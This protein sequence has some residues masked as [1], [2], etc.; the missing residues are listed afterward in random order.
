MANRL[1]PYLTF[2][3]TAADA[4]AFYH[5]VFGGDLRVMRFSD[6]GPGPDGGPAPE[7]VMHAMLETPGGFTLMASDMP[8]GT[9]LVAG[10]NASVS[11]S[12]DDG[13]ELRRFWA[14]LS[15]GGTV[16]M[17]LERQMWGDEFGHCADRFGTTWMVNIAAAP[18]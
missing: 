9:P 8:P 7:G 18:E 5:E 3:G 2:D 1:N 6:F 12:G 4:M 11:L 13:D 14:A 10:N 16:F 15:E 17:E